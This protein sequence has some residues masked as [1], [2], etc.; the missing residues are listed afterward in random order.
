MTDLPSVPDVIERDKI[1]EL[2]KDLEEGR[3]LSQESEDLYEEKFGRDT[4]ISS[5]D[6]SK[7]LNAN[8]Q[9]YVDMDLQAFFNQHRDILSKELIM[10]KLSEGNNKGELKKVTDFYQIGDITPD[11]FIDL[12]IED[13]E[14]VKDVNFTIESVVKTINSNEFKQNL[15]LNKEPVFRK[16]WFKENILNK[17]FYT[18]NIPVEDVDAF[19]GDS[20]KFNV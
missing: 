19:F 7:I 20:I 5:Q 17:I 18:K 10:V 13:V 3:K 4:G 14:I 12:F 11:E 2:R 16:Y 6:F 8:P 15:L 9:K 1:A